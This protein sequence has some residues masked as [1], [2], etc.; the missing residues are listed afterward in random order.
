MARRALITGGSA[1]LGE[2]IARQF[3]S[4]LGIV[5]AINYHSNSERAENLVKELNSGSVAIKAD[6]SNRDECHQL[7]KETIQKLGG[8]DIIVSNAG[9][10]KPAPFP[11]LNLLTEG[12]Q[13]LVYFEANSY[14]R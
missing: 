14:H 12:N 1:G 4:K 3:S 6:V 2:A 7:V 9:W 8:L 11:D 5:C 10:T 13:L